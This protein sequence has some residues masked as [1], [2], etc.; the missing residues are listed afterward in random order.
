MNEHFVHPEKWCGKHIV[1]T[2]VKNPKCQYNYAINNDKNERSYMCVVSEIARFNN[3]RYEYILLDESGPA[4]KKQFSVQLSFSNNETYIGYGASIKKAQQSAAKTALDKTLLPRPVTKP[5]QKDPTDY[6]KLLSSV[7]KCLQKQLLSDV[8]YN[9]SSTG[10]SQ[11]LMPFSLVITNKT[12]SRMYPC[13][14]Y[15]SSLK[16]YHV[17]IKTGS[18][19]TFHGTGCTLK[20]AKNNASCFVLTYLSPLLIEKSKEL[21]Q[22]LVGNFE[23]DDNCI[24]KKNVISIIHEYAVKMK[25][26]VEFNLVC[27]SGEPHNRIYTYECHVSSNEDNFISK[28]QGNSKKAAKTE[29]CDKMVKQLESYMEKPLFIATY[30]V[31]ISKKFLPS[32]YKEQNKRRLLV[33]DRKMDPEYGHHINPISRLVQVV[34]MAKE[35]DPIFTFIDERSVF[36]RHE[37]ICEVTWKNF[38]CE[39]CGP[40][41]KLSKRA[42]AEALLEVIGYSKPMKQ[43]GKSLLKNKSEDKFECQI[44]SFDIT[45]VNSENKKE[46]KNVNVVEGEKK[47]KSV[48]FN[49]TIYGCGPPDE[50]DYPRIEIVPLKEDSSKKYKKVGKNRCR[51]LNYDDCYKLANLTKE[52]LTLSKEERKERP[53]EYL[54]CL[55]KLYRFKINVTKFPERYDEDKKVWFYFVLINLNLENTVVCNGSGHSDT[56]AIDNAAQNIL[57][58]L[59]DIHRKSS[60]YNNEDQLSVDI[61]NDE[62]VSEQ[63]TE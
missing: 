2:K 26:N 50:E 15:D 42:A 56:E 32:P 7:A 61:C 16:R 22:K 44:D 52:Y 62:F 24:M 5:T 34:Q 9:D 35:P 17:E 36:R 40:T 63:L 39:G 23:S 60:D 37:F 33:K 57:E 4:H 59:K 53:F 47:K 10:I 49:P 19:L 30:F 20:E 14:A 29:A 3:I 41:K 21:E 46:E 12:S 27:E 43:P 58:L 6:F 1:S 11:N 54:E 8:Y 13:L 25:M 51:M 28:G 55:S 38:R 48:S 45:K 18:T 31:S